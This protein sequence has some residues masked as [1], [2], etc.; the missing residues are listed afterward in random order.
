MEAY[1]VK[2]APKKFNFKA[3]ESFWPK[4][5]ENI[6]LRQGLSSVAI[7]ALGR[8]LARIAGK[9]FLLVREGG[10][11]EEILAK[12]ETIGNLKPKEELCLK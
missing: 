11:L 6:R 1:L 12:A 10:H 7:T 2:V 4:P 8:L 3:Y 5:L 9:I